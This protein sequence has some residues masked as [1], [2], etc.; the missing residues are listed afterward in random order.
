MSRLLRFLPILCG[1]FLGA[2]AVC[3][4]GFRMGWFPMRP[5]LMATF[6]VLAAVALLAEGALLVVAWKRAER[7]WL[8]ALSGLLV[9]LGLLSVCAGGMVNWLLSLQGAV[10]LTEG[11]TVMLSRTAQLQ[12]FEAGLLS[13]LDEMRIALRLD[14]VELVAKDRGFVPESRLMVRHGHRGGESFK[15]APRKS[16]RLGSLWFH[17]GAFGFSPRI[18]IVKGDRTVFD[19]S[20]PFL[21]RRQGARG[22]SFSGRFDVEAEKISAEGEISLV[23]LDEK[24]K[25]HSTL[26]LRVRQGDRVLGEGEL[27]PGQFADLE[28]SYRV[29]FAGLTKWSEIDVSRRNYTEPILAGAGVALLGLLVWPLAVWRRW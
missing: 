10:F 28:D 29:G 24:M 12:A 15:V 14:E 9:I 2:A 13:N 19:R 20:V 1:G 21:T 7:K 26:V 5:D 6:V 25:G 23:T 16:R 27:L 18:V 11:E 8:R 4:L 22:T 17:Q 3:L